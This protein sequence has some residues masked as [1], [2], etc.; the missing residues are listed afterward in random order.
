MTSSGSGLC[1]PDAGA[2]TVAEPRQGEFACGGSLVTQVR[3]EVAGVRVGVA[4]VGCAQARSGRQ[5]APARGL[6]VA[7]EPVRVQIGVAP[8]IARCLVGV[9]AGLPAAVRTSQA[10]VLSFDRSVGDVDRIIA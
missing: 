10:R 8:V 3:G 4:L 2:S 1:A 5:L 6:G 7:A 9:G